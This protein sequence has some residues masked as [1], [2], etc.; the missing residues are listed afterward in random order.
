MT[1][2]PEPARKNACPDCGAPVLWAIGGSGV[3]VPMNP[4]N[5]NKW[6]LATIA[7]R[8][9]GDGLVFRALA[10]AEKPQPGEIFTTSHW[11]TC[12]GKRQ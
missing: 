2:R 7:Y 9:A 1:A 12:K 10:A 8:T 6:Q 4:P 5:P 3:H 11:A